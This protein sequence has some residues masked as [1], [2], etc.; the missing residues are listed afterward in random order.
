M[1]IKKVLIANRGEIA[2]RVMRTCA[3]LGIAT[4]AVYSDADAKALHVE[5]ADEAY[6]IGPAAA[7]ESYL[8]MEKIIDVA[9]KSGAD[10]IHPGY[11]FL[12]ENEDF[13][14]ACGKAGIIFIG[15]PPAAIHAMG[16]KSEAKA[17]MEKA[18]VPLVPGYHGDK[19][20][21]K[22][23]AGE[24][25]KIG[26]PVLIKASSG[27]G[28]KGMRVVESA[29]DFSEQLSGAQR[30]AKASFGDEV[31]LIEKYLV[32]PR[33]V[34]IQVFADKH[35]NTVYLF[36]R[37]CSV[38]RRHQKVIEEAPAPGMS[39]ATRKKMGEA[40]VAAAKA[41]GY[42][43]A[44]TV[45]FLLDANENFY[46]ME[47]NTRLQVEHPVTE[48]ITGLDLVELQIRAAEGEKLPFTQKDLKIDGHAMEVRLYAE[49]PSNNF[50]PGAG[51]IKYLRFP[52][53]SDVVRVDT[54][55][56]EAPFGNGDVISIHYDPMIAKIIVKGKDRAGAI[57]NLKRAL[58]ETFVTGP[59]TNLVFLRQLLE[60]NDFKAG[61][62]ST[63]FIKNH[64]AELLPPPKAPSATT[65]S[66]AVLGLLAEREASYSQDASSPWNDLSA[67]RIGG[68]D[69]ESF[70]FTHD[71]KETVITSTAKAA[72]EVTL[73][74]DGKKVEA[75]Y[76]T[77]GY[78]MSFDA[79]I[80]GQQYNAVLL[81]D[82]RHL[83]L[84]YNGHHEDLH[85]LDPLAFEA[86]DEDGAGKLTA[87]M[88]GKVVAV[89][90]QLGDNVKKGQPLI[91]VEAM[92]ME[93]TITAPSDGIVQ[94]INANVGDQVDEK[95][96]LIA[97]K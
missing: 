67:W 17:L 87:P 15:P 65:L 63:S 29:K 24:A 3:K 53:E 62:V 25:E 7:R 89:R 81:R 75:A 16:G 93:H 77:F 48:F 5:I 33:H 10:A 44:G 27:G 74:V 95:L 61:K 1:A 31:V 79:K 55:V 41:I 8:V 92:K 69:V 60:S 21:E 19:Q 14:E 26:Y 91:I 28:G 39:E 78:D 4:V 36:E 37:D 68:V 42:V 6:N 30:E 40:A 18:K 49:D 51:Q 35:G 84:M 47:M 23:L 97:F 57:A 20:D 32:N 56:R 9:K 38:Q 50:L 72:G 43:G 66:L 70:A 2:C 80:G 52:M 96:E 46:F 90:V 71:G 59:K 73:T 13:A 88:P 85:Y 86:G 45:E 83:T 22:F 12:S 11:G 82:G 76:G 94:A 34:E 54:G 58:D 64:E